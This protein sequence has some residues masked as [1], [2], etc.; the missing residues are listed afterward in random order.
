M[1]LQGYELCVVPFAHK[2][3]YVKLSIFHTCSQCDDPDTNSEKEAED[4][5][6][7]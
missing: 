5:M 6:R 7:V 4:L 3:I 2:L 1:V